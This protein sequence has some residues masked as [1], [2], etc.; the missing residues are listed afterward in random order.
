TVP[1]AMASIRNAVCVCPKEVVDFISD[2]IK[3]NDNR[4]NKFSDNYYRA[5][6]INALAQTITPSVSLVKTVEN[7]SQET[8]LV[9]EE[10]TRFLNLEKL[11]PCYRHVVTVSCLKAIRILQKNGWIPSDPGLFK[12]YAEYGHFVDIRVTALE[13]LVDTVK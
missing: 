10:I 3:Y 8:K 4:K 13:A 5:A 12:S 6:L 9:V 11:L 1:V 2:L 7:L